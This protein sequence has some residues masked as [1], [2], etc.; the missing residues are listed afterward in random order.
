MKRKWMAVIAVWAFLLLAL[1]LSERF[2]TWTLIGCAATWVFVVY[3]SVYSIV[4]SV[5]HPHAKGSDCM[6]RLPAWLGDDSDQATHLHPH[7]EPHHHFWT[8]WLSPRH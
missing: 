2:P 6:V 3:L 7:S 4:E 5:R 1:G 8:K